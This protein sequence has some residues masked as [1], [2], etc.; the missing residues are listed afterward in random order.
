MRAV[1]D[2]LPGEGGPR[3]VGLVGE[4]G[5]GKTTSAAEIVRSTE[6]RE[7]F[8]DGIVW[9]S[10]NDGA[11]ERLR[12]LMMHLARMVYEDIG[13]SVGRRPAGLDDGAA[14]IKQRMQSGHGGKG[15]KCLV[16]ADNVW[17]EAVISKLLETGMWVL[18]STRDEAL[19]RSAEG[20]VVIG[21]DEL[22]QEDAM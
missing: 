17:K 5:S 13:G 16:V 3:L 8:S 1:C 21:V 14:Y 22:S 15:L 20:G 11:T 7:A 4:S 9:L 2:A 10:V 6:V 19:V 12:A 18:L